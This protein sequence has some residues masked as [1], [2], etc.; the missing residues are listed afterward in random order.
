MSDEKQHPISFQ[1]LAPYN[2]EVALCGS[3]DTWQPHPMTRGEDG[4][5]RAEVSLPDGSYGYQFQIT[6]N[7]SGLLGKKLRVGDP[8]APFFTEDGKT[9]LNVVNGEPISVSYEW[10]HD[11][12]WLPANAEMIIYELHVGDFSGPSDEKRVGRFES[13]IAKLD[14]L[15][16]LGIN[17]I[18]LMPVNEFA[19]PH[20]WGYAQLS[21]YAVESRYGT[22]DDLCRLVDECHARGIRVIHDAVYNHL[23]IDAPLNQIDSGY[24]FH[25]QNPDEPQLQFGPK[26]N[27]DHFDENLGIWPARQY[28]FDALHYW[29]RTYHVDGI[30]F[31]VTRALKNFE[32]LG[33]FRE[34]LQSNEDMKPLIAIAEHIPE[35][36]AI[37]GPQG[38]MDAA[39]HDRFGKQ[40]IATITGREKDGAQPGTD[41]LLQALDPNGHGYASAY[42]QINYLDTHDQDRAMWQVQ[43]AGFPE[44]AAM[45]RMKLGATLLLTAP[46]IP[47]LWMGQEFGFATPRQE[48]TKPLPLD[49]SLLEKGPNQDLLAFYKRLIKLR[50]ETP[51]LYSENFIVVANWADQG[52]VSYKR[53][54]NEGSVAIIVANLNDEPKPDIRLES[55]QIENGR[56]CDVLEG[57]EFEVHDNAFQTGLSE[58]GVKIF[59]KMG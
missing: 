55:P 11:Q 43:Q 28:I 15:A 51:A 56:W 18:E 40:L 54:T 7:N 9:S 59:V 49:W 17:A 58:S 4:I 8:V 26:L 23:D 19:A 27:Y 41:G 22:P 47:M 34:A 16:D 37:A 20:D 48:T 25:E 1:L 39:W 14:Y 52:L 21:P 44:E 50:K 45:R 12:E 36:P 30:R 33:W 35:D 42:N 29:V 24:W 38:P 57:R 46:G 31:D 32:L 2:E 13:V 53:W 3:W 10:K 6:S 5:W